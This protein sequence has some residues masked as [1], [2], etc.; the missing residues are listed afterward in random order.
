[1]ALDHPYHWHDHITL[2]AYWFGVSFMWNAL[3]P[4]VLP[5]LVLSFA[6]ESVKNTSYGLLTF[7]GLVVAALVQPISGSLSDHT[8]HR[9]GRRRPWILAGTAASIL[10]LAALA[11]ANSFWIIAAFYILL[12]C[13][14]NV[15]HGPAQG[16]MRDA[17]PDGRRGPAAG[18]KH[19][20]DMAAVIVAAAFAGRLMDDGVQDAV[21]M[22]ALIA[23]ILVLFT[24]ITSVTVREPAPAALTRANRARSLRDDIA[25]LSHLDLDQHGDYVR[26]LA[27][28]FSVLIGTYAVQSFGLYYFRDV[29]QVASASRTVS[30]LM[31]AIALSIM[32]TAVPAGNLSERWGRKRPIIVACAMTGVGMGL[33][34][35]ARS[36]TA[37]WGVGCLIGAGMGVFS[38]VSFAWATD[39]V[40]ASEA[41]KYLGLSNLSTAGAAAGARLLGPAMDLLNAR[42]A[43]AGYG[44]LFVFATAAAFVGLAI[45]LGIPDTPSP[46]MREA[47][48]ADR[49]TKAWAV[50]PGG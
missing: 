46:G 10:C 28:R 44:L 7:V 9:L 43:H 20:F 12:Q 45:A 31:S 30:G 24:I 36:L 4:I 3:H 16:L 50:K 49:Q 6:P 22:M 14:S 32:V 29:L 11:A 33:L 37:L 35:A 42:W 34:L 38:A 23:G 13:S 5:V 21:T 18:A 26:L 27:T 39:M 17:V 47:R 25:S 15:A 41:G 2:N 8:R 40:P 48:H 1:M 19:L